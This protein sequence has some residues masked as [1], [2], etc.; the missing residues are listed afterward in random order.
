MTEM[1]DLTGQK[2]NRWTV[3][4]LAPK[5]KNGS[6]M[7]YCKC[8]CGTERIVNGYTLTSGKSK[9]CGCL[10]VD[11][12]KSEEVRAKHETHGMYQSRIYHTWRG[13]KQRCCDPGNYHYIGYGARGIKVCDE[14][15]TFEG[16]YAWAMFNGY[17]DDL[18]IDRIDVDGNY[19]PANC[20]WV[21]ALVQQNNKRNN[22]RLTYHGKTQTIAQWSRELG[23][24][25]STIRERLH[26]G[27]S[28]E[29][30][31]SEPVH[32]VEG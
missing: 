4:K 18:T 3:I 11:V 23:I 5:A 31:L 10:S 29:R 19:E 27:W 14:W 30:A 12:N 8:D 32:S 22:V 15:L 24:G 6:S 1:I 17:R 26:R 21:S 28:A 20:R 7:W 25:A 13:I 2:F 9:S 16:F